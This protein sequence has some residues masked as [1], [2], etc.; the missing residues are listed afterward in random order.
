MRAQ[1]RDRHHDDLP[2]L[3]RDPPR[4]GLRRV[5]IRLDDPSSPPQSV[6]GQALG[7]ELGAREVRDPPLGAG[8]RD[9]PSR[10]IAFQTSLRT[11]SLDR[12]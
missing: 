11:W 3:E 10:S 6:A 2:L 8:N 9:T 12:I 5:G 7:G 1:P 4:M